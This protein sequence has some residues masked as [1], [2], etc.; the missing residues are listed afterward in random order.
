MDGALQNTYS[1][2]TKKGFT[3]AVN[4]REMHSMRQLKA[5][6][7]AFPRHLRRVEARPVCMACIALKKEVK[8]LS[9]RAPGPVRLPLSAAVS[10]V[11]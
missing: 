9:G 1:I 3:S 10:V 8:A 5:A 4:L 11:V 2:T 6:A 7:I